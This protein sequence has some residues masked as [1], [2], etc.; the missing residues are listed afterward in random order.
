LIVESQLDEPYLMDK[1]E[2]TFRSGIPYSTGNEFLKIVPEFADVILVL[3][4][5]NFPYMSEPV[6]EIE[7]EKKKDKHEV[8]SCQCGVLG[9][10]VIFYCEIKTDNGQITRFNIIVCPTAQQNF[11]KS[12]QDIAMQQQKPLQ[13]VLMGKHS[14]NFHLN[15]VKESYSIEEAGYNIKSQIK[16]YPQLMR[17][18][19][20]CDNVDIS[21]ILFDYYQN[22]LYEGVFFDTFQ[23]VKNYCPICNIQK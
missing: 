9:R 5:S 2:E 8:L 7:L 21:A 19:V 13:L 14:Y 1:A 22:L 16:A 10:H 6:K 3:S 17:N 18:F 15:N 20:R 4:D 11:I 23:V 12:L